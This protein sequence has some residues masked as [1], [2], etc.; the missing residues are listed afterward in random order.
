MSGEELV[1]RASDPSQPYLLTIGD[2]GITADLG[3]DTERTRTA[4]RVTVA[5][6]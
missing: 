3:G 1:S 2:I 4:R 6:Q 5:G